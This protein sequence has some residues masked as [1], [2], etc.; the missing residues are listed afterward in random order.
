MYHLIRARAKT[1]AFAWIAL[2]LSYPV[3]SQGIYWTPEAKTAYGYIG[4]LRIDESMNIIRLQ[5]ITHPENLI[6]PYL[7]DYA[8]FLQIFLQD[9]VREVPDYLESSSLRM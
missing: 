5:S 6:W 3:I 2:F 8:L 7:E 1:I 9:D 4:E